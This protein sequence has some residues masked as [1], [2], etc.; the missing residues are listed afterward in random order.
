M[1]FFNPKSLFLLAI[2][3]C[4]LLACKYNVRDVGFVYLEP[5]PYRVFGYVP[6]DSP[7]KTSKTLRNLASASFLDS[8]VEF[9]IADPDKSQDDDTL[10]YLQNEFTGEHPKLALVSPDG[11]HLTLPFS[12]AADEIQ[13]SAWSALEGVVSSPL[14]E[15]ILSEIVRVYALVLLVEGADSA[16]NE[17]AR[18]EAEGAVRDLAAVMDRF[19]KPIKFPPQIVT[20]ARETISQ[21]KVFLWSL[22]VED[23]QPS[24]P[25]VAVLYGRGRRVG[26]LLRGDSIKQGEIAKM[27]GLLGQDCE[28]DLDRAWMRGPLIPVRWDM[29]LQAEVLKEVGFDAE[30][31]MIK[32]EVSRILARGPTSGAR[33]VPLPGIDSNSLL[34]Y[35]E[36]SLDDPVSEVEENVPLEDNAV[37][38]SELVTEQTLPPLPRSEPDPVAD[39]NGHATFP[40][41]GFALMGFLFFSLSGGILVYLVRR[42]T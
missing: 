9:R 3:Q 8:N 7:E 22:G 30:N 35:K 38:V 19:P 21:E 23:E 41:G 13:A 33:R 2:A 25:S 26:P 39:N 28:C 36:M 29:D 31:P 11:R 10:I 20:V 16:E 14:R 4:S 27:L 32:T 40:V 17:R 42:Q 5:V 15:Q 34:G 24:E 1:R 18:V 37:E 6:P 12:D